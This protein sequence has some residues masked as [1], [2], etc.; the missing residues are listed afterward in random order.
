[1]VPRA[2]ARSLLFLLGAISLSGAAAGLFF[3]TSDQ[4][5]WFIWSGEGAFNNVL[6][7]NRYF[8]QLQWVRQTRLGTD[9][10]PFD[11]NALTKRLL[12]QNERV[13]VITRIVSGSSVP[14]HFNVMYDFIGE[15]G[16]IIHGSGFV[17]ADFVIVDRAH[18]F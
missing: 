14:P 9:L 11:P 3:A 2:C 8:P 18:G 17:T 15:D 12:A 5:S 6:W 1:M 10:L 4:S 7:I 16:A 13:R